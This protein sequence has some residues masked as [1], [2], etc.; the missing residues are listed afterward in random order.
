MLNFEQCPHKLPLFS[1]PFYN[2]NMRADELKHFLRHKL[3]PEN[4]YVGNDFENVT[5]GVFSINLH[6]HTTCSDGEMTPSAV[7]GQAVKYADYRAGLGHKDPFIF[8][9][10]D[11]DT[12]EGTLEI[13]ELINSS[14]DKYLNLDFVPGIEFNSFYKNKPFEVL[15]YGIDLVKSREF[16]ENIRHINKNYIKNLAAITGISFDYLLKHGKYLRAGGSPALMWEFT[17][18]L[19]N[20]GCKNYKEIKQAHIKQYGDL[21]LNP[22]SV[23]I[24]KLAR[25][26]KPGFLSIAHPGRSLGSMN[27]E[28]LLPEL[29][30][31]GVEALEVNYN[32]VAEDGVSEELQDRIRFIAD[33][34]GF[35]KSGGMDTHRN[36]IFLGRIAS[37]VPDIGGM[38]SQ[39]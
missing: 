17:D 20:S 14:P 15:A 38:I 35:I 9:V 32:Y 7:L 4:F 13:T 19:K 16:I 21:S 34:A 25:A 23:E 1:F 26:V 8:S 30:G 22:G 2:N 39:V 24:I 36:N 31:Q 6:I 28:K 12:I 11:H 18:M 29:H 3:N 5:S 10:T 33:T 37:P 27:L